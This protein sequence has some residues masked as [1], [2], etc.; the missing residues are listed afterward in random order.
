MDMD[1][2][3]EVENRDGGFAESGKPFYLLNA[4]S[5]L[6]MLPKDVL[7]D[8]S[9]RKEA[10][11]PILIKTVLVNATE[12]FFPFEDFFFKKVSNTI[13]SCFSALSHIQ[14]NNHQEHP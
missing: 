11:T 12:N 8:T 14:L 4:L 2:Y 3:S 5:D 6:L 9:T 13:I 10:C 1:D 7:M